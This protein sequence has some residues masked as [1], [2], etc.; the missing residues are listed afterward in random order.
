M[1]NV[2]SGS[3]V[4]CQLEDKEEVIERVPRRQEW[5]LEPIYQKL[6]SVVNMVLFVCF[7]SLCVSFSV[8][9][10]PILCLSVTL[11]DFSRSRSVGL[12]LNV[13]CLLV[14]T[15]MWDSLSD[16]KTNQKPSKLAWRPEL[17]VTL[18]PV[19]WQEIQGQT[20]FSTT[21]NDFS[22]SSKLWYSPVFNTIGHF[23][24]SP[25]TKKNHISLTHWVIVSRRFSNCRISS[26]TCPA[27][28]LGVDTAPTGVC[29][30]SVCSSVASYR[31]G[32]PWL[33]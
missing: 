23:I 27:D 8:S 14:N 2:V 30:V 12:M 11:G 17:V 19:M 29:V 1:L 26:F 21:E 22:F 18:P 20:S 33:V 13:T 15:K 16:R 4:G 7:T 24:D 10:T 25:V 28:T 31:W 32:I 3:Q 9:E 6:T 5:W